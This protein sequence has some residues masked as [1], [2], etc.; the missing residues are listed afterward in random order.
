MSTSDFDDPFDPQDTTPTQ[1]L[2]LPTLPPRSMAIP[3]PAPDALITYVEPKRSLWVKIKHYVYAFFAGVAAILIGVLI[4]R[5]RKRGPNNLLDAIAVQKK[6]QHIA[7]L[8]ADREIAI[9]AVDARDAEV[10]AIDRQILESK[11]RIIEIQTTVGDL[12]DAEAEAAFDH[13]GY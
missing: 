5:S 11:K 4:W 1:P 12:T 13:L 3:P 2:K 10:F 8:K 7:R 6:R 9:S